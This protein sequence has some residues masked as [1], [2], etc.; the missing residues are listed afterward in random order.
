MRWC[1]GLD[2]GLSHFGQGRELP[3]LDMAG[4]VA[5]KAQEWVRELMLMRR[6]TILPCWTLGNELKKKQKFSK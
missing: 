5:G 1:G 4:L 3:E 2:F 6:A